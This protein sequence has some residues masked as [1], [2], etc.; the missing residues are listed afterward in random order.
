[1]GRL[2]G[3]ENW[4]IS[5]GLMIILEFISFIHHAYDFMVHYCCWFL[6]KIVHNS[7][8]GLVTFYRGDWR[9]VNIVWLHHMHPTVLRRS[10]EYELLVP[11]FSFEKK[12]QNIRLDPE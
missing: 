1:M 12:I 5:H 9:T 3:L 10:Q 6:C 11:K 8:K 7:S 4:M 2:D